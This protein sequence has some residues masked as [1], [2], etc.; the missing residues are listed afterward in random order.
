MSKEYLQT[1]D[2]RRQQAVVEL[3]E[4]VTQRYPTAS[5]EIG[6]SEEDPDVTHITASVDIDDPEEV[7]DLTIERELELQIEEGI[8]VY[9]IPI[10]TPERVA[11]L[12]R[13]Q[14]RKQERSA[15]PVLPQQQL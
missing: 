5:F 4:M 2:P 3:T 10:R 14:Q 15:S 12:L 6:P 8:P 1:L 11:A 13:Q 9:L 7:T